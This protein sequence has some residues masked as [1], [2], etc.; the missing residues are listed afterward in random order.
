VGNVL[1][2]A[3]DWLWRMRKRHASVLVVY[4]RGDEAVQVDAQ[5]VSVRV[6]V[7]RGDGVTV[8]AQRMDWLVAA[9]DLVFGG[10]RVEPAEGDVVEHLV[11]SVKETYEVMP[12]G[13][14]SHCHR[15]GP[16]GTCWRIHSKRIEIDG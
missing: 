9:E 6:E 7:D 1:Q 14:E 4:R 2:T 11:G 8:E 12:V 3:S 15:L 13:T 10:K 5:K 16:Y